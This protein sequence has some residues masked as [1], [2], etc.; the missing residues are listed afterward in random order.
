MGGRQGRNRDPLLGECQPLRG[1]ELRG[2]KEGLPCPSLRFGT[3]GGKWE[4][5]KWTTRPVR[6]R[7]SKNRCV[8]GRNGWVGSRWSR[9]SNNSPSCRRRGLAT[10]VS[11][12]VSRR[13]GETLRSRRRGVGLGH[14]CPRFQRRGRP[15]RLVPYQRTRACNGES[16]RAGRRGSLGENRPRSVWW[17]DGGEALIE[18]LE[19]ALKGRRGKARSVLEELRKELVGQRDPLDFCACRK[20]GWPIGTGRMESSWSHWSGCA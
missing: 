2:P 13:H 18:G 19:E 11:M 1:W 17:N 4:R 12:R 6:P 10:G 5:W 8:S 14:S 9:P 7:R 16:R 15:A 3:T 20:R